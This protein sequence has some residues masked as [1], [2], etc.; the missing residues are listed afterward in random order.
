MHR[1]STEEICREEK[2]NIFFGRMEDIGMTSIVPSRISVKWGVVIIIC[3]AVLSFLTMCCH[4]PWRDEAQAWLIVRDCPDIA[5][6]IRMT[7]YE[8]HPALWYLLLLPLARSGFPFFSASVLNFL[9]I[10]SAVVVFV[11]Y[12]PFSTL[13]K[14]LFVF[15]YYVFYEYSVLA[16][17]YA[18]L[19]LLLFLIAACY[20]L[21]FKRPVVFSFLLLLLANTS[22]HGLII[23][24]L[25]LAT[26]LFDMRCSGNP[27]L[28]RKNVIAI[29]VVTAG[30]S[31][32]V[33]Q[34][35]PPNDMA[36]PSVHRGGGATMFN[37]D[38]S[39]L[40]LAVIP[41]ALIGAF[42]PIPQPGLHFWNSKLVCYPIHAPYYLS[43]PVFIYLSLLVFPSLLSLMFFARKSI[44]LLFYILS[45]GS[46]V[47]LFFLVYEAG[48]RHQGLL[49]ILFIFTL[50]ISRNYSDNQ[51]AEHPFLEKYF[52]RKNL[53]FLLT[54][55]LLIQ[56]AAS[57]VAFHAEL[58]YD[59]SSGKKTAAYL[60]AGGFLNDDTLITTYPSSI[61]CSLLPYIEKPYSAFYQIE[62]QKKGSYMVWNQEFR[63][64][65]ELSLSAILSK[66]D[67]SIAGKSYDRVLFITNR[68]L[69]DKQFAGRY[70]M[71]A[72]FDETV[73]VAESIYVY[74]LKIPADWSL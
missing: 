6:F 60:T 50:W 37:L 51:F 66:I 67:S 29:L 62:Y 33:L 65:N 36:P 16:R 58:K 38:L 73:E 49:Y 2:R 34:L 45:C 70:A 12:A 68:I 1:A 44:P 48:V 25:L 21:R 53:N 61:A 4:E 56:A 64:N 41:N 74:Q 24:I 40:H 10:L 19:V 42:L 30:L 22:V 35:W 3:Y 55:F 26:G 15:G 71:I 54:G 20:D 43:P 32:C 18:L 46:L 8:G 11:R 63:S 28:T 17:N 5:T 9:I 52:S 7:G 23:A 13:H 47:G 39:V 59:F 27:F 14:A 69:T 72:S 57:P 31:L